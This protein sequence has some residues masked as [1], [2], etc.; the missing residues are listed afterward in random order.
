MKYRSRAG[1]VEAVVYRGAKQQGYQI[2]NWVNGQ[3]YEHQHER[4]GEIME[5]TLP[6]DTV[7][8]VKPG[9]AVVEWDT[10]IFMIVSSKKFEEDYSKVE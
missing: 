3:A 9:D 7:V 5:L 10:N 1:I 8:A 6:D 2:Q 4:G